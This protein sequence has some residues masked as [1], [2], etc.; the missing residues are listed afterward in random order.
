MPHRIWATITLKDHSK[1][2]VGVFYRPTDKGVSSILEHESLLSEIVDK[3]SN[4]PKITLLLL[5]FAMIRSVIG[6]AERTNRSH[7]I[8]P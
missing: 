7:W 1:L 2:V 8:P 5:L 4:N 3:F 6:V